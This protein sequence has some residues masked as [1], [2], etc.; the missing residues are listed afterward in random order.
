M[1]IDQARAWCSE[2]Y[3]GTGRA[4]QG[5]LSPGTFAYDPNFT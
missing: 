4:E 1:A 2:V 5:M 3:A